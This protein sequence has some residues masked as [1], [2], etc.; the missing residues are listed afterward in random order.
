MANEIQAALSIR[1]L[2]PPFSD[3]LN[4]SSSMVTQNAIGQAGGTQTI[5]T[6]D[7]IISTVGV[8]TFGWAF[9][10]NLDAAH[11]VLYGP[12]DSNA[13]LAPFGKL[14]ASEWAWL[15]LAPGIVPRARADTNA[16]KM[17]VRLYND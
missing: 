13:A 17:L 8:T 15:R 3:Q 7:T 10:Q 6:T 4:P 5:N 2:N 12:T 9:L 1:V 14:E 16:V 11:Y